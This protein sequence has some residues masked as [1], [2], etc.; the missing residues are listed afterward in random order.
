MKVFYTKANRLLCLFH[1]C[2]TDVELA[3]FCSY[4]TWFYCPFL[5]THDKKSTHSKLRVAFN[6]IYRRILKLPLR[7]SA[8]TLY[9]VNYIDSFEILVRKHVVG[10]IERLEVSNRVIPPQITQKKCKTKRLRPRF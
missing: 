7:S 8:S 10:F 5:W 6:N 3:L 1:C 2:S 9:T 4:C